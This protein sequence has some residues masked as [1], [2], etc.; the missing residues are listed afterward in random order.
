MNLK[1][2]LACSLTLRI[3]YGNAEFAVEGRPDAIADGENL[4]PIPIAMLH[5]FQSA[6]IPIQLSTAVFVIELAPYAPSR[7][8]LVSLRLAA[9]VDRHGAK[10]NAGIALGR[11]QLYVYGEVESRRPASLTR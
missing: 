8:G 4:I 10:L 9:L 3:L 2:D 7:V 6:I 5:C 11:R 1:G